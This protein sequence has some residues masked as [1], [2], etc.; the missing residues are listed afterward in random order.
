[1]S[2]VAETAQ[3]A[4]STGHAASQP[5]S[6]LPNFITVLE[7]FFPQ[8]EFIR[9][10]AGW[11]TVVFSLLILGFI[12]LRALQAAQKKEFL[13][14]GL[15]N[16]W[17]LFMESIVEFV[18]G[19]LGPKGIDHAPFLGT[20]FIYI[21]FENWLGLF[22]LMK[23]P[24]SSWS[25][26]LAL[27]LITTVY[28]QWVGIKEQGFWNYVKHMAGN[29]N[30]WIGIFLI[31]IMLVINVCIEYFA[32]PLSLS[33][34]LFA[35]ISSEDRLLYNFAQLNVLYNEA[36]F[37]FQIFANILAIMFG[38]IQAFVFFLLSAIYIALMLPHK[39]KETENELQI[40]NATH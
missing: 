21:L 11:E 25:T 28:V 7:H 30:G 12:S 5:A 8:S 22:P 19:I 18:T 27:A 31:P 9:F 39:E 32:V 14:K 3:A 20:L 4:L 37:L 17:E 15:Q 26:T 23:S 10:L 16:R 34:R 29:P 33:L 1:M 36:F 2:T 6:E 24:T 38:L 35:N 13:P 40:K